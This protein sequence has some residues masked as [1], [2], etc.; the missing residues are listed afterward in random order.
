[1]TCKHYGK[2]TSD[3]LGH[4]ECQEAIDEAKQDVIDLRERYRK[5]PLAC[6]KLRKK[7]AI[8]LM[9][10]PE[11]IC[12]IPDSEVLDVLTF[13]KV[14]GLDGVQPRFCPWCG[15]PWGRQVL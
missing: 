14:D 11:S 9:M 10:L 3:P 7:I 8:S 13:E 6:C 5:M 2:E 1:M 15:K 12:G 4:L